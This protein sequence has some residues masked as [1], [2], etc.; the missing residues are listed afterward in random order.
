MSNY[1]K[2]DV[3]IFSM[4]TIKEIY[5]LTNLYPKEEKYG[6]ISQTN[7]AAVSILANIAEGLGRN[8][9]KDTI[10]F[11]HISRGSAYEVETLLSVARDDKYY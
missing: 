7:R 9:K 10:Q 2:L 5:K 8:Y 6:L 3:W 4:E 1:K 11:L